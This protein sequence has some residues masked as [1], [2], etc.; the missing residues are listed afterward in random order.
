M[1][2]TQCIYTWWKHIT[3]EVGSVNAAPEVSRIFC[4]ETPKLFVEYLFWLLSIPVLL[5]LPILYN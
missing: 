4:N 1:K 3:G 5:Q 2:L